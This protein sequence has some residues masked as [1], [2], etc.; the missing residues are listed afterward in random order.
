M[1]QCAC[2]L[3][4]APGPLV[5]LLLIAMGIPDAGAHKHKSPGERAPR[6]GIITPALIVLTAFF[7]LLGLSNAGIGNFGVVALMSGYGSS[8]SI[9][10]IAL[11]FC[12]YSRNWNTTEIIQCTSSHS[13]LLGFF[14]TLPGIWRFLQCI[15]RYWDTRHAFPHLVNAGKYF[16]TI[17]MYTMLSLWRIDGSAK[18]QAL[19]IIFATINSLYTCTSF[20]T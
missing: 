7:T 14:S 2:L 6:Q 16:A 15:R 9:A 1:F 8:F 13:R 18:Y 19:F 12:L 20:V 10:N 3:A 17:L 5:A 4:W 11:F